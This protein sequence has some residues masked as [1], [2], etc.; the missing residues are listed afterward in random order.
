MNYANMIEEKNLK[1]TFIIAT[2]VS[3]II[4]TFTTG[5]GLYERLEQKRKQ[6]KVDTGQDDKISQLQ[7]QMKEIEERSEKNARR[8]REDDLRESLQESGPLIR[9]EYNRDFA[10]FGD[11]FAMG[12]P[13]TQN[14]LQGQII[15]LQGTV[16]QLLDEALR[17]GRIENINKLYNAT[18]LARDGS[19]AALQGQY[20]RM[21]QAAPIQRP[22]TVRRISSQPSVVSA[23][24]KSLPAPSKAKTFADTVDDPLFCRYSYDLQRDN[25]LALDKEFLSGGGCSCFVCGVLLDVEPG[26]AWKITKEHVRDRIVTPDYDEEIIE[27]RIYLVNNRFVIKCHRANG[28]FACVLC[29]RY[30]EKDTLLESAQGLIRHIW[31]KHDASEYQDP[32]IQEIG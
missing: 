7:K 8:V 9:R 15:T 13:I 21:L 27:D 26:R 18:E 6:K 20:Q 29:A 14:Q 25:R 12:D 11:R 31:N 24:R 17:T 16:I 2:L 1:K 10:R 3:T 32:D 5:M 19:I 23:S 22:P 4:G 30:R 28:G